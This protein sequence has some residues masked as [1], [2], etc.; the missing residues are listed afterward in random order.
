MFVDTL[1]KKGWGGTKHTP[2]SVLN[3]EH[4]QFV[5]KK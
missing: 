2:V 5:G 4:P 3:P 1:K